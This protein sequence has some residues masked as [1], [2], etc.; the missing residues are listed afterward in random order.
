VLLEPSPLDFTELS[1]PPGATVLWGEHRAVVNRLLFAMVRANDPEPFW[2]QVVAPGG[3]EGAPTPVDL[4]WIAKERAYLVGDP[5]EL[6]PH[7][8]IANMALTSLLSAG[9]RQSSLL[10]DFLRLPDVTQELIG[11]QQGKSSARALGIA[12][13]DLVRRYYPSTPE[14]VAPFLQAMVKG[15]LLPFFGITT[16]PGRGQWAFDHSFEVRAPSL[17]RWEEGALI[18]EKSPSSSP[19]RVGAAVRLRDLPAAARALGGASPG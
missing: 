9:E 11:Y 14:E 4:G 5:M 2:V 10:A 15:G 19:W 12:N 16:R 17:E 7:E 8:A 18:C 13:V 1:R 3:A 6:Q